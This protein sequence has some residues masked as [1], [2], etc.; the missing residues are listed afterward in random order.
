MTSEYAYFYAWFRFSICVLYR[1]WFRIRAQW[2][3]WHKFRRS[4]RC[5]ATGIWNT[6]DR[7]MESISNNVRAILGTNNAYYP[8]LNSFMNRQNRRQL[9]KL[10]NKFTVH[11]LEVV[12]PFEYICIF[13]RSYT[14]ILVKITAPRVIKLNLLWCKAP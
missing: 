13:W 12:L 2:Y 6:H 4:I 5:L 14:T 9:F 10:V 11:F 3:F 8:E 7:I 1:L